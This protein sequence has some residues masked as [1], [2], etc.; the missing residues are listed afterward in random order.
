MANSNPITVPDKITS[1]QLTAAE[2]NQIL[3][4]LKNGTRDI[5]ALGIV[6][7][8]N[9][10]YVDSGLNRVGIGTTTPSVLFDVNGAANAGSLTLTTALDETDGGTGNDTYTTGD[11]LYSSASNTLSKLAV[12]T[13]GQ[14]L[15]LAAGVPSWADA[16]GGGASFVWKEKFDGS[17]GVGLLA[18]M[19]VPDDLGG[20]TIQEIRISTLGLPA[21]Q[22]L[23]VDVRKNGTATTNSVFTSDVE[24]E[25][26]TAQSATNGIYQTGCDT[27]GSTVG[28]AGT[29]LDAAQDDVAADDVL[30][31][32]ITQTG[33]TIS[34]TD[35][36]VEVI[37]A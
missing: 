24:I 15:T 29:T 4:A 20:K 16:S 34:G 8:T 12:G 23:K 14:V 25:I 35:L 11:I 3:D 33:S 37:I 9:T 28:T 18:Y 26:G 21:G 31:V 7:D 13:N 5:N 27:A 19:A 30:Y 2:F 17:V 6:G 22:A 32:Y 1:D 10:I 36:V